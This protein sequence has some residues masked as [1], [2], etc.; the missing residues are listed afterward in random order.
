MRLFTDTSI[1]FIQNRLSSVNLSLEAMK[2]YKNA[3]KSFSQKSTEAS[4]EKS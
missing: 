4:K 3:V 2:C 1:Q